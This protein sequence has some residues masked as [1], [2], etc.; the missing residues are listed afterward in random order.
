LDGF[1]HLVA[2]GQPEQRQALGLGLAAAAVDL[3][4]VGAP[5]GQDGAADVM[6]GLREETAT[7]SR[8]ALGEGEPVAPLLGQPVNAQPAEQNVVG[9]LI[10][11]V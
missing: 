6:P 3:Q 9:A 5:V 8:L 1:S 10:F 11:G 7:G 4:A 2:D